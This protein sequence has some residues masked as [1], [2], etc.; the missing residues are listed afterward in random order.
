[1]KEYVDLYDNFRNRTGEIIERKKKV[2]SGLFRLIVHVCI[3]DSRARLLIQKRTKNK[4]TWPNLWDLTISGAVS[5][6]ETS[7]DAAKRELFEELGIERDF[8]KE[9]PNISI[10][11]TSRIDDVYILNKKNIKIDTIKLQKDEVQ[12]VAYKSLN[13]VIRL[14]NENK[15]VPYQ[16]D[17]I[18]LLFY[19]KDNS[20][21]FNG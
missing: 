21:L 8:S 13:G 12:D 2:P 4:K 14:I 19:L 3:F 6:G 15:F 16:I 11:T 20:D 5:S 18:K 7:Q 1:M 9:Y 10:K 17:Y